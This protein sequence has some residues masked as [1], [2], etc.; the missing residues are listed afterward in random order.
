MR[1]GVSLMEVRTY[2]L[3]QVDDPTAGSKCCHVD[4]K[5]SPIVMEIKYSYW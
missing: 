2:S 4:L 3:E 5:Y 1:V